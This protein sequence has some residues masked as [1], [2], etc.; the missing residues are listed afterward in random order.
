MLA[1]G[2]GGGAAAAAAAAARLYTY[3]LYIPSSVYVCTH[4]AWV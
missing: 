2:G 4:L 1:A 3:L